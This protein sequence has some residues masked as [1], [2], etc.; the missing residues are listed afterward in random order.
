MKNIAVKENHLYQKAYSKGKKA[1]GRYAVV[2]VMRD[3]RAGALMRSNPRKEYV[4]RLGLT[5]TKRIGGAVTRNRVKRILREGY[6]LLEK[7]YS[8]RHGNIVIIV[9]R[10]A[11]VG[12]KST[13][14][15]KELVRSFDTLGLIRNG[16]GDERT[17]EKG[18]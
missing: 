15:L 8:V 14:V 10:D 7:E 2:Y 1:V 13:D 6:R 5:V 16:A 4:N 18:V 9:A 3:Y 17:D 11:A 12:A